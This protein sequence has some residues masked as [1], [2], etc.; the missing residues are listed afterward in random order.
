VLSGSALA[1]T[2][3]GIK[4][5]GDELKRQAAKASNALLIVA[6][7]QMIGTAILLSVAIGAVG[8]FDRLSNEGKVTVAVVV[9]VAAVFWGLYFWARVN[10]LPAAIVGLVVYVT[11]WIVD[12]IA[13]FAAVAKAPAG[14]AAP[15]TSPFSGIIVRIIIIVMLVRAIKAGLQH[16]RLLRQQSADYPQF[17][18]PA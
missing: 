9:G 12:L 14:Q 17:Q 18:N 7:L 6:I 2:G 8:G 13:A 4:L 15:A 3:A 16:R 5:Q 11:L 10:P 1:S